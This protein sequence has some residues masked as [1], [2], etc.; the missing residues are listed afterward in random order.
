MAINIPAYDLKAGLLKDVG[1]DNYAIVKETRQIYLDEVF[2][3]PK[4]YFGIILKVQDASN[5]TC[6]ARIDVMKDRSQAYI[7]SNEVEAN[8]PRI[9][10]HENTEYE[11]EEKVCKENM[12]LVL[13]PDMKEPFRVY[14]IIIRIDGKQIKNIDFEVRPKIATSH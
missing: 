2:S 1:G 8:A 7:K 12:Y 3:N 6:K 9:L 13:R 5:H 11:S 14:R 10:I 4:Y